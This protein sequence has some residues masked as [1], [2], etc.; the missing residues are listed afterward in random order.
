MLTLYSFALGIP[1]CAFL[2]VAGH[3]GQRTTSA[4]SWIGTDWAFAGLMSGLQGIVVGTAAIGGA[5]LV[6]GPLPIGAA[7]V[8]DD[9]EL[10]FVGPGHHGLK[11]RSVHGAMLLA[12]LTS[13]V[14]LCWTAGLLIGE[15]NLILSLRILG[16]M[17]C[18]VSAALLVACICGALATWLN[19]R[20]LHG[21]LAIW[22]TAW[23]APEVVRLF[24]PESPTC[25]SLFDWF[26]SAATGSWVIH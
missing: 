7:E 1:G 17:S 25:R 23:V 20:R 5:I 16:M 4:V 8:I 15:R 9:F 11:V 10:R 12:R 24:A 3:L 14:P 13:I 18:F 21:S 6:R 26:L 22:F 19:Q 2:A